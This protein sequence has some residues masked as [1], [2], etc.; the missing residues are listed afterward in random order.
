MGGY[1]PH[2][3]SENELDHDVGDW[4]TLL[5]DSFQLLL[6]H[7]K[8]VLQGFGL[9]VA[10]S[11]LMWAGIRYMQRLAY[12]K[13]ARKRSLEAAE[14]RIEFLKLARAGTSPAAIKAIQG[15]PEE[16]RKGLR[17]GVWS[18]SQVVCAALTLSLQSSEDGDNSVCDVFPDCLERAEALDKK[19]KAGE[20]LGPLF[21][22]PFSVKENYHYAGLDATAGIQKRAGIPV[23]T[24]SPILQALIDQDGVP[25]VRTNLPQTMLTFECSNPIYGETNNPHRKGR[26][27]G[28]SSGG[29]AVL[30]A[31]CAVPF[32]LGGDIG[33]SI[34]IPAHYCGTC[35]FKPTSGRVSRRYAMNTCPGQ[36]QIIPTGGPMA[37]TVDGLV[38]AMRHICSDF[39][40]NLDSSVPRMPFN[41]EMF[42]GKNR[43]RIGYFKYPEGETTATGTSTGQPLC[44]AI[45]QGRARSLFP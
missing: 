28:G 40:F 30:H 32:G 2:P 9:A 35:G 34:R 39:M 14:R 17:D 18:V 16:L 27:C 44:L 3:S 1:C 13:Q 5:T 37:P 29:E 7:P 12:R 11:V 42:G 43:M 24:T 20:P 23:S 25:I 8:A 22:I 21:G 38:M 45:G 41:E 10:A 36:T 19:R 15:S 4:W 31:R 26:C 6:S 33:G